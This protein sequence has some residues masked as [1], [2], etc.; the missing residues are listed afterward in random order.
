MILILDHHSVSSYPA[1]S[2]C[3]FFLFPFLLVYPAAGIL[4]SPGSCSVGTDF[5][6]LDSVS[7]IGGGL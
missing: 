1:D 5:G 6:I 7:G 3:D 2:R 4:I